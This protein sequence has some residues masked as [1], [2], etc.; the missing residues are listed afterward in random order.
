MPPTR[1]PLLFQHPTQDT[2]WH[3]ISVSPTPLQYVV[4]PQSVNV[5]CD[6]DTFEEQLFC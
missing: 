4:T 5:F 3:L 2:R 1:A 6:F